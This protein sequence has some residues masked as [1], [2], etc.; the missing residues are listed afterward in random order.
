MQQLWKDPQ[1]RENIIVD[2]IEQVTSSLS[3]YGVGVLMGMLSIGKRASRR[4]PFKAPFTNQ[5]IDSSGT[6]S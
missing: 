4:T 2:S 6:T 3:S 1:W 5:S